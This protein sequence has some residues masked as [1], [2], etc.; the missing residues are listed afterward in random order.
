M[1]ISGVDGPVIPD[2]GLPDLVAWFRSVETAL[3]AVQVKDVLQDH[4]VRV[5]RGRLVGDGLVAVL[6]CFELP[7]LIKEITVMG[8]TWKEC[9]NSSGASSRVGEEAEWHGASSRIWR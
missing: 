8:G 9:G 1:H 7:Y 5:A 3:V 6:L 2:Q 4:P